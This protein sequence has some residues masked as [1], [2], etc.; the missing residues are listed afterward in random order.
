V[1][2]LNFCGKL[3]KN[4]WETR[5]FEWKV[6]KYRVLCG[7]PMLVSTVFHNQQVKQ[8]WQRLANFF[9]FSSLTTTKRINNFLIVV[10]LENGSVAKT[11]KMISWESLNLEPRFPMSTRSL[12]KWPHFLPDVILLNVRW[13]LTLSCDLEMMQ[14][15]GVAVGHSTLNRWVWKYAPELDL[16]FAYI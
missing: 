8:S 9:H 13:Y 5:G 4:L 12:F 10:V 3:S 7:N 16:G 15:R 2:N 1:E 14:E 6:T 11:G